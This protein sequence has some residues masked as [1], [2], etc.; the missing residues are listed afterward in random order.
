MLDELKND[1]ANAS[2][3]FSSGYRNAADYLA[4]IM[5]SYLYD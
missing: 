3:Y 1:F 5:N 4:S 2:W